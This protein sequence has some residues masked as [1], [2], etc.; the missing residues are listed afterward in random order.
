L[1]PADLLDRISIDPQVCGGRPCIRG[2]RIR[3]SDILD[4]LS[5]GATPTE[6]LA[7]YDQIAP[8]DILAAFA[9]AARALDHRVIQA[10]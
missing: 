2:T 6:I 3:V 9:Y 10:A 4:M 8:D 1:A 5:Q 7:D